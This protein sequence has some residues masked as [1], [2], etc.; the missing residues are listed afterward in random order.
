M[1]APRDNLLRGQ[2]LL[3]QG[4][5]GLVS[6]WKLYLKIWGVCVAVD[7]IAVLY[8]YGRPHQ[9]SDTFYYAITRRP[10]WLCGLQAARL[11]PRS[12]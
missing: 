6:R 4:W 5:S 11:T 1:A 8:K 7:A 9:A 12:A 2:G 10:M 3:Q